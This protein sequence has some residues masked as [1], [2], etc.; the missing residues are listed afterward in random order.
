MGQLSLVPRLERSP[1]EWNGN[2]P[3]YSG[4][5]NGMA[6]HSSIL[7]WRM[8]WQPTPVFWHGEFHGQRSLVGYSPWGHKKL[9]HDWA[10]FTF[11]EFGGFK[12]WVTHLFAWPCNKLF[13]IPNSQ[14]FGIVWLLH[15]AWSNTT[16]RPSKSHSSFINHIIPKAIF[17]CPWITLLPLGEP[18][19]PLAALMTVIIIPVLKSMSHLLLPLL[20]RF[21][22]VQL[23]ATP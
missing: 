1:G 2:P 14:H 21:S 17:N 16:T 12:A 15:G 6:T 4:M 5:E 20:S 8:E 3:Q 18:V 22:R 11:G 23:C 7:A 9:G 13:S 19:N 10:T